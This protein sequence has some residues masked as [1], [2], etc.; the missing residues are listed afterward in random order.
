MASIT[1]NHIDKT[2]DDGFH[3]IKDVNLE[4]E[5][6]E[7]VILVGPSGSGK[8]TLL[9]MI[10][11]LEDI[12]DGEMLIDG[13]RVN[14]AAPKD[15][16]LAMVFQNYALYPHL[17][18]YENIAFPLRLIKENKPSEEEIDRKVRDAARV[19]ELEDHL[20]R[21]PGN[22]SGGQRQRV[23]MGRAI[24]READAF[25]F[26]EPLSN[27]DAKL[28]GQM[29]AEISQLQRRLATTSIYVTHD[30]TEAMT[31]GDR[32]AVL[33]KGELQQVASPRELYEQPLNLFVA[34]FIGSP[35]MNFLP[36]SL[37][38]K[39]GGHVLSSP[40]GDIPVPPEKA[41]AAEGRDIVFLGLRPEFFEDAELVEDSRRDQGSTFDATLTHLE[42]LG[43]EQY[44]YI[45]FDPD[46]AVAEML[47]SLA[48]DLDA[49]ELRPVVVATLSGE[50]RARPGTPTRLW[51]DTT[52]VHLFDPTTGENL[53]RDPEVGA[54]LT[55]RAAE[56][57]RRQIEMAAERDAAEHEAAEPRR[58]RRGRVSTRPRRPPGPPAPSR[59]RGPAGSV[60]PAREAAERTSAGCPP[61]AA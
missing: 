45:E 54:E 55:R 9:R 39:E 35:S 27:L 59:P 20:E 42:W 3:A 47:S 37:K 31:L 2:Y 51:V 19:L 1:L 11:G 4:I 56:E 13:R 41:R 14:E 5:D 8:S 34:G 23:A 60:R 46:P 21:K 53:T 43:H 24:V 49:D 50:S 12:T 17:T 28:R 32:V 29:R 15:R 7:F 25:L 10:V 26:D 57:R 58:G 16:N 44:G 33:K 48:K 40:I 38:Q 22:L 6:G 52:R 61:C 30:Q 18:V 36:A